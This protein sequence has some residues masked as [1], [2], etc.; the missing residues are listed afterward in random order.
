MS[1][2]RLR[3]LLLEHDFREY[4]TPGFAAFTRA[5]GDLRAFRWSNRALAGRHGSPRS[6]LVLC[7]GFGA[8]DQHR[9]RI[10]LVNW[11][12]SDQPPRPWREVATEIDE[13]ILPLFNEPADTALRSAASL[14]A[15]R[16]S[17]TRVGE[18]R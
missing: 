17:L 12:S 10:P 14:N 11:P 7:L 5:D 1:I 13:V 18:N 15:P 6:Y 9:L 2:S 4:M 16:Y 8:V 3:A